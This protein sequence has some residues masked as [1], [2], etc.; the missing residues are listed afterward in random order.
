MHAATMTH[1][2]SDLLIVGA[3]SAGMY[4]AVAAAPTNGSIFP[5]QTRRKDTTR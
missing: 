3:G 1:L 4:A 2:S 5:R